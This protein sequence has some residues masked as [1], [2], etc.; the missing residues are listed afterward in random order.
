[1]N[2]GCEDCRKGYWIQALIILLLFFIIYRMNTGERLVGRDEY[3]YLGKGLA[4]TVYTSGANLR[5]LGTTFSSTNQGHQMT[6]Y[7]DEIKD[8]EERKRNGL[9]VVMFPSNQ[10]P[11]N[12]VGNM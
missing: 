5:R 6:V 8:A 2:G 7:N 4:D 10:I 11:F 12:M 9:N 3:G 1:M